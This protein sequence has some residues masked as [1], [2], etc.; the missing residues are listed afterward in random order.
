MRALLR[1]AVLNM[2]ASKLHGL[3]S[4]SLLGDPGTEIE[5]SALEAAE[6]ALIVIS[7]LTLD[8][9]VMVAEPVQHQLSEVKAQF[10]G[11]PL[12]AWIQRAFDGIHLAKDKLRAGRIEDASQLVVFAVD[13]MFHATDLAK[14]A[15][16]SDVLTGCNASFEQ[17]LLQCW[18]WVDL[19][20]SKIEQGRHRR[21]LLEAEIKFRGVLGDNLE[22]PDLIPTTYMELERTRTIVRIAIRK[23]DSIY[24]TLRNAEHLQ[25]T[26]QQ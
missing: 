23:Q 9:S 18:E 24:N 8:D 3:D 1:K 14:A 12:D 20:D 6:L 11:A 7:T 13:C 4:E 10:I 21:S 15:L 5:S 19:L 2:N 16:Q 22:D 17:L 26:L 25:K